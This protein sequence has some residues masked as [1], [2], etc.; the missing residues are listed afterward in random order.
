M[1]NQKGFLAEQAQDNEM[2][3]SAVEEKNQFVVDGHLNMERIIEK[4]VCHY[5]D[6]FGDENPNFL[7]DNG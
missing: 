6:L 4:F 5:T 2:A 3:Q 7:E 1:K